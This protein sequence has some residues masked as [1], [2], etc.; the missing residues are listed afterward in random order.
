[1][2][3]KQSTTTTR[4][5]KH[6][7]HNNCE[8]K[9]PQLTQINNETETIPNMV[10]PLFEEIM[11]NERQYRKYNRNHTNKYNNSTEYDMSEIIQKTEIL[12]QHPKYA[13]MK[14]YNQKLMANEL[15]ALIY[16]L[17]PNSCCHKMKQSYESWKHL[18][19][20]I[21]NAV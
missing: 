3:N 7:T 12:Q 13:L 9:D 21:T 1:M 4:Q 8:I 14:Q 19:F 5:I 2:Q 10:V 11:T 6:K 18:H 16:Y 15:L 17:D 20:Y